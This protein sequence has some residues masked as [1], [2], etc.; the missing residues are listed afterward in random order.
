MKGWHTD[1]QE[2]FTIQISGVK[3]WTLRRGRV[4]HPL[5]ATTPHYKRD[6]SVVEN[7]LK[8]ARLSCLDGN[9]TNNTTYG[10]GNYQI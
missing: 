4:T 8:V 6:A 3:R 1:F 10:R 2:N 7:Q 5:R 9:T